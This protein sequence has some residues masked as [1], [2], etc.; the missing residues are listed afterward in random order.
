[1]KK[2]KKI[3]IFSGYKCNNNCIFC[4]NSDKR[5]YKNKTTEE[6]IKEI[7]IA[8]KENTDI[9][10]LI[11]GETTI[12]NDFFKIIRTAKEIGIKDI[13]I[14]TNGRMFSEIEF[15][16]KAIDSGLS[17]IIFSVHGPNAKIHD[18]LTQSPGSFKELTEGMLNLKKLGFRKING[19]TTVTGLNY[20]YI[21]DVAALYV[22]Y[23]IKNVEYI[24]VDPT[25]SGAHNSFDTLVPKISDAAPFMRKAL[26]I[27]NKNRYH[28]WKVRYVPLCYFRKYLDQISETNER[29]LFITKHWAPDF[30]DNDVIGGRANY[31][32]IKTERCE[33]GRLYRKCEGIWKEYIKRYGDTE[34]KKVI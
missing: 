11:G 26:D 24:F 4:I 1:M 3:V 16:K 23:K 25:Y 28:Q 30:I 17:T 10:E 22:K 34:L 7:Y 15:A 27:G 5:K 33:G 2:F 21:P 12:R 19:N 13:V 29:K 9:I 20:R 32:R 6:V 8:K 31:A 14:A 18:K